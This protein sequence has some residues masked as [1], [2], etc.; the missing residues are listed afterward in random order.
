MTATLAPVRKT[1]APPISI[2][3]LEPSDVAMLRL[4]GQ[5]GAQA[6]RQQ[7]ERHR[8]RSVWSP[9]TLEFAVVGP[10]RNRSEIS[11][12]SELVA[13]RHAGPLLRA[14]FERCASHGDALFLALELE[15]LRS[16]NRYERAGMDLLEEVIT[17]EMQTPRAAWRPRPSVRLV[18]VGTDNANA[19]DIVSRIDQA[20]FP[21][22]WRNSRLELD[23]YVRTAG[24]EVALVEVDGEPVGYIG[25]TLFSGWGHLD[26]I[27]VAPDW[28]GQGLGLESLGLAV[29]AMRCRG[30]RRV[31]LST[32]RTNRRSQ[33]L[34][35]RFGFRRTF[36]H[37]YQLFGRW[38]DPDRSAMQPIT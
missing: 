12:V 9:S 13:V 38:R 36:D 21:W 24:V 5:R 28:Q 35:E 17:Y 25:I 14:A 1:G 33:R 26:R 37:D 27:A 4:P 10:W 16:P 11:C 34:Y 3:T 23:V 32:Q 29:D 15:T 22:L 19:L 7:I 8:G 30:A 6:L 31:A 20:A 2:Q 18:P